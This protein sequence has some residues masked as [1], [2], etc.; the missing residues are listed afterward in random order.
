M[1]FR[2][3]DVATNLAQPLSRRRFLRASTLLVAGSLGAAPSVI[4]L[5]GAQ[6]PSNKV[7]IAVMGT[8]RNAVGRD[9]WGSELAVGFANVPGVEV[10]YVCDVDERNVPRAIESVTSQGK[11]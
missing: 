9:G 3:I 7:V 6:A 1:R 10:G 4:S 2:Q 5:R 11:Q 8:S